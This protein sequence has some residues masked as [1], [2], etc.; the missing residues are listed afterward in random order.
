MVAHFPRELWRVLTGHV[1]RI[2]DEQIES[3][4]PVERAGR[5][6]VSIRT[7]WQDVDLSKVDAVRE[8]VARGVA[9]RV[10]KSYR[11]NVRSND[12]RAGQLGSE[13][14]REASRAGSDT[15][16]SQRIHAPRSQ[17]G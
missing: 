10:I 15:R 5:L 13:C 14:D 3:V 4:G 2:A 7:G 17:A 12:L 8:A 6:G 11:R 16:H 9:P 1:G